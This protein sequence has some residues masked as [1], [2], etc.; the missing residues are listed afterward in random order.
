MWKEVIFD[1]D[2]MSKRR[3][4]NKFFSLFGPLITLRFNGLKDKKSV[5]RSL[6][7]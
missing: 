3:K 1:K 7:D 2:K 5:W 4:S 6:L